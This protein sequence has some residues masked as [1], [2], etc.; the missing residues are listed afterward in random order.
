[1]TQCWTHQTSLSQSFNAQHDCPALLLFCSCDIVGYRL[2]CFRSAV[3][4]LHTCT[5]YLTPAFKHW[6]TGFEIIHMIYKSHQIYACRAN[7]NNSPSV[8]REH[9][10]TLAHHPRFQCSPRTF[11][12]CL[13]LIQ[14]IEQNRLSVGRLG[15]LYSSA[16]RQSCTPSSHTHL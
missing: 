12:T 13:N 5:H 1:M 10:L 6:F 11:R 14:A 15:W 9:L 3:T 16:S 4:R 8:M 2:G 7:F